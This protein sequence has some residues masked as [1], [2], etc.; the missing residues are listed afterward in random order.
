M[1]NL[2]SWLLLVASASCSGDIG[3]ADQA[4]NNATSDAG[5]NPPPL[6]DAAKNSGDSQVASDSATISDGAKTDAPSAMG[7]TGT[8][9]KLCEDFESSTVGGVPTG[10]TALQGWDK[11][12][13]TIVAADSGHAHS[14]SKA[15]KSDTAATGT[16]RVQK[17]LSG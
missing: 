2:M 13:A 15:V 17:S 1:R 5:T 8:S 3:A 14:G 6:T 12:A 10:W 7:C 11:S 9:Y 16:G 4:T